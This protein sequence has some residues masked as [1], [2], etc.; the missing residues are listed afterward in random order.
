MTPKTI[1]DNL[2][3]KNKSLYSRLSIIFALF[4]L[5][6]VL[7]FGYF[8]YKYNI[9]SDELSPLLAL[10][11]LVASFFGYTIIRKIFDDISATSNRHEQDHRPGY[12]RHRSGI[13]RK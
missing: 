10:V 5:F 13:R 6:P 9:L 7:A 2:S 1:L 4:F 12:E 8:A 11:L 3:L